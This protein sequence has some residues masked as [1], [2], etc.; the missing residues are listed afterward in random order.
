MFDKLSN[1]LRRALSDANYVRP[2]KVQEITI[3][4]LIQGRSVIVQ[5]ETGSGKL[6]PISF[7][8]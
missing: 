4:I 3:P 5:A 8:C 7:R 6:H 2:T 1:E